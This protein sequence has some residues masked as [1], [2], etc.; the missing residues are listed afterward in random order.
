MNSFL[1]ILF[2]LV[3]TVIILLNVIVTD[4]K[5]RFVSYRLIPMLQYVKPLNNYYCY[6]IVLYQSH[7]YLKRVV[8]LIRQQNINRIKRS[9]V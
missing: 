1:K 9:I 8:C 5:D 3:Q 4:S 6:R 7:R 2:K